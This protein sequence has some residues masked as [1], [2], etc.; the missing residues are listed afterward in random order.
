MDMELFPDHDRA[1]ASPQDPESARPGPHAKRPPAEL[2]CPSCGSTA[3]DAVETVI[4]LASTNRVTLDA[5]GQLDIH[6]AG[7][8]DVLDETAT[9]DSLQCGGCREQLTL[10]EARDLLQ[11][12]A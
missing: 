12:V 11:G 4:A 8:L 1:Y 9:T 3:W 2:A 10:D 5:Q 7:E 6:F